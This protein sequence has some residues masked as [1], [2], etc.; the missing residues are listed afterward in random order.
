L[1]QLAPAPGQQGLAVVHGGRVIAVDIFGGPAL[2]QRA[3]R[4]IA[5][6]VL[7][8]M[9]EPATGQ[10]NPKEAVR[11]AL[12]LAARAKVIRTPAPGIGETLHGESSDHVVGAVVHQGAVYHLEIAA[13]A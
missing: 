8:E 12:D 5:R 2:Y 9:F 1:S 10:P 13:S 11:A 4:K 6:G 7:M 3:W